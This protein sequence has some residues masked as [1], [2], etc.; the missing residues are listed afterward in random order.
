MRS[1]ERMAMTL[2]AKVSIY[3]YEDNKELLE[4]NDYMES[5]PD[6][7]G[8]ASYDLHP[9]KELNESQNWNMECI[10]YAAAL[11]T[12][13]TV[14]YTEWSVVGIVI[15][16][17]FLPLILNI[18][19]LLLSFRLKRK[20]VISNCAAMTFYTIMTLLFCFDVGVATYFLASSIS[21]DWKEN[22][23]WSNM[24]LMSSAL[25]LFTALLA[26]MHSYSFTMHVF[27]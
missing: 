14:V 25:L 12:L 13:T 22:Y 17:G 10:Y 3:E 4:S 20:S 5:K 21:Y 11:E 26:A 7:G 9:S 18:T 23:L 27:K 2:N 15:A 6:E 24:W 19:W 1:S 8:I 16:T